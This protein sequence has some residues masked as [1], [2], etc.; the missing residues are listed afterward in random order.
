MSKIIRIEQGIEI[1]YYLYG[2]TAKVFYSQTEY[3]KLNDKQK[4]LFLWAVKDRFQTQVMYLN[5][6]L[7]Y[8]K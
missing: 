4:D 8:S 1:T 2:N 3:T 6:E 7:Y 5:N